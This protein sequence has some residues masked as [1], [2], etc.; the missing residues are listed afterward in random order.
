MN[1][2]VLQG[3]KTECCE[4]S[5][6]STTVD[7]CIT[8][9]GI[10]CLSAVFVFLKKREWLVIMKHWGNSAL[11][12]A[13]SLPNQ[14]PKSL[15]SCECE[16]LSVFC[17]SWP[18]KYF[19]R[20]TY[21]K[22]LKSEFLRPLHCAM[23]YADSEPTSTEFKCSLP[24][25]HVCF[26]EKKAWI[27]VDSM[28]FYTEI[29]GCSPEKEAI[30]RLKY[31]IVMGRM[32]SS[33]N[34]HNSD[35]LLTMQHWVDNFSKSLFGSIK[36][37]IWPLVRVVLEHMIDEKLLQEPRCWSCPEYLL[38][39]MS[40]SNSGILEP[41]ISN[42]EAYF[43]SM[44]IS[45]HKLILGELNESSKNPGMQECIHKFHLGLR[46]LASA[47]VGDVLSESLLGKLGALLPLL[48]RLQQQD[49][50]YI[51][52]VSIW[53]IREI[54]ISLFKSNHVEL[55]NK[56]LVHIVDLF[57][58]KTVENVT[59]HSIAKVFTEVGKYVPEPTRFKAISAL[60]SSNPSI[61]DEVR[62]HTI[63]QIVQLKT[64]SPLEVQSISDIFIP[65]F[66]DLIEDAAKLHSINL[67]R[68]LLSV[69]PVTCSRYLCHYYSDAEAENMFEYWMAILSREL[70]GTDSRDV[71]SLL[72]ATSDLVKGFGEQAIECLSPVMSTLWQWWSNFA[73][74]A[75]NLDFEVPLIHLHAI[76]MCRF[77]RSMECSLS[78][79]NEYFRGGDFMYFLH[80]KLRASLNIHDVDLK[81]LKCLRNLAK[82][83]CSGKE[84]IFSNYYLT[85]F[86]ALMLDM[87]ISPTTKLRLL[88][89]LFPLQKKVMSTAKLLLT[90]LWGT[91]VSSKCVWQLQALPLPRPL[92]FET[93]KEFTCTPEGNL[94]HIRTKKKQRHR[95]RH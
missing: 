34:L 7:Y 89:S 39:K 2:V 67:R 62:W 68:I 15:G 37:L 49:D 1:E 27:L 25:Q 3:S 55:A 72:D 90:I 4:A 77:V 93:L 28:K 6:C 83:H 78:P 45:H 94:R 87:I 47:C 53:I 30:E 84:L 86:I 9:L 36:H 71:C 58:V 35:L 16:N 23:L 51:Q 52:R 26:V 92:A 10:D 31:L 42:V 19:F 33:L 70:E 48:F 61:Q 66:L 63:T 85:G 75:Q 14:E 64:L 81:T 79:L 8:D 17:S 82:D 41:L 56:C 43:S 29:S 22:Y 38:Y 18:G 46:A 69:I 57:D 21:E 50:I 60:I 5:S 65:Q 13:P 24:S 44:H 91:N 40:L 32:Q 76:S 74:K 20:R 12:S 95:R 80:G 11:T 73:N 88:P 59:L 54:G